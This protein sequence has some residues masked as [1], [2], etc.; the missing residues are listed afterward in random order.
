MYR[1]EVGS[2]VPFP[3][4]Y[5][6]ELQRAAVVALE[7]AGVAGQ[8]ELT[9][10]LTGEEEIRRLNRE[11]RGVDGATDVLSF[12]MGDALPDGGVYLGDVVIAMPIAE[13]QAKEQGHDLLAELSLLVIHGVL[14]LLGED[15]VQAD[16][17]AAMWAKQ[18]L[19]LTKLGL[20]AF[21]S[22]S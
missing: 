20:Q 5:A 4:A 8:A 19:L 16:D 21:P 13:A 12:T 18:S 9:V 3:A 2:S 11:Y 15:H 10:A 1:V 22:E 14:H 6:R 17:R 7:H